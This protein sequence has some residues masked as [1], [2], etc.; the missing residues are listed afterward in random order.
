MSAT[1]HRFPSWRDTSPSECDPTSFDESL[2]DFLLAGRPSRSK[3][4]KVWDKSIPY[5]DML[6]ASLERKS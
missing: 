3:P 5:E 1:I 2:A 6:T 4:H